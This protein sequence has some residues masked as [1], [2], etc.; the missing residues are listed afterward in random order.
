MKFF[1]TLALLAIIA[2]CTEGHQMLRSASTKS[3]DFSTLSGS[4]SDVG[5]MK[6]KPRDGSWDGKKP[7]HPK[8]SFDGSWGGRHGPRLPKGSFDGSF[9]G[10]HKRAGS[11]D[12]SFPGPHDKWPGSFDGSFKGHGKDIPF[13]GKGKG[14]GKKKTSSSDASQETEQQTT[15]QEDSGSD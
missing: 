2:Q 5:S 7:P 12:G 13:P 6:H 11:F 10:H 8:G 4:G 14:K 9:D 1:S 3:L 15:Q